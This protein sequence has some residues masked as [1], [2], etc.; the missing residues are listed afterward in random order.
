MH[1]VADICV[2]P[3]GTPSP[4][5]SPQI[6]LAQRIIS[7]SGLTYKMHGYGT[8]IEGEMSDVLKCIE[9]IHMGLHDD[10]VVRVSSDI[11]IGTRIDKEASLEAKVKSV[12]DILSKDL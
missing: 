6:A 3:I 1:C 7:S 12:N 9:A 5:V 8:G 11:R 4:S 2:I 10:G